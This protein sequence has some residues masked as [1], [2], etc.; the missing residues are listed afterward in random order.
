MDS[1]AE[2][3]TKREFRRFATHRT[4]GAHSQR[5][6]GITALPRRLVRVP[7]AP[8]VE[9]RRQ[10]EGHE[11]KNVVHNQDPVLEYDP[12]RAR[13][14]EIVDPKQPRS[15]LVEP[16]VEFGAW[17]RVTQETAFRMEDQRV[18][19]HILAHDRH[20]TARA[21]RVQTVG[22]QLQQSESAC[23]DGGGLPAHLIA[24]ARLEDR[25]QP[26]RGRQIDVLAACIGIE[27]LEDAKP[28]RAELYSSP[29]RREN[30][31]REWRHL[32]RREILTPPLPRAPYTRIRMRVG[33]QRDATHQPELK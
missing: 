2:S 12:R 7:R 22:L 4:R 6:P 23:P 31:I 30:R 3:I 33:V 5:Q 16:R 18:P 19:P 13:A 14:C 1:L 15:A 10:P 29:Y 21:R 28:N 32:T 9:E 24:D 26:Q 27:V 25:A 20:L 17:T 8:I 11:A